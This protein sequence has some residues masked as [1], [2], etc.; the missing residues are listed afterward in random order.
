MTRWRHFLVRRV[1]GCAFL[2]GGCEG[3]FGGS[4]GR[5]GSDVVVVAVV[6]ASGN[7]NEGV[8]M[9][10]NGGVNGSVRNANEDVNG[11]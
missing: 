8:D 3:W 1:E 2:G 9:G 11:D 4:F 7:G 10:E 6:G 5:S